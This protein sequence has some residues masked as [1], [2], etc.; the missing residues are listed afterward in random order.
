MAA[1]TY[2]ETPEEWFAK[3]A[4]PYQGTTIKG[5][6]ERTASSQFMLEPLAPMFEEAT[7]INIDF[8]LTSW[9][10]MYEKEI[11]DMEAGAGVYDF[12]Y[13]EQDII[14]GALERDWLTD[15]TQ[16]A[17]DN[18]D[19]VYPD[20]DVGDF[21]SFADNFLGDDGHLYGFPFE[22]FLK[23]YIYRKDLFEDPDIQAAFKEQYGWD[24]RPAVNWDEYLQIA[25]FFTKWGEETGEEFWGTVVTAAAHPAM[26]YEI[27]ETIW[28][29][30]GVYNWGIN[31]DNLKATSANGGAADSPRAKEAL[32]YW[33]DM[34]ENAPPEARMSTWD[35]VAASFAGGRTAQGFIYLENLGW[36]ALDEDRSLV[37]GNIGVAM[38]PLYPGVINDAA[39]QQGYVGYYDG[40]ALGIPHSSNNKEAAFLWLQ[41]MAR[42]DFQGDHA[43]S[44]GRIT[45]NSTFDDPLVVE[46]DPKMSNYFTLMSTGGPLFKGAPPFPFHRQLFE[47]YFL[48]FTKAFAGELTPDEACDAVAQEVDA[49]LVELGYAE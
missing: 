41:W 38:P 46:A 33:V 25:E 43:V 48:N 28:P 12:V 20:N 18:P 19:L 16:L 42:K 23:T 21:T 2:A 49:L 9:D 7:G 32:A 15:L 13:I 44:A 10:E 11:K 17:A 5:V 45:R 24:L 14:F 30:W 4:E 37:T 29:A 35:E 39:Q 36:M 3:A 31:M 6:S 40:G 26:T 27:I 22:A 1:P 8:E 47:V 34:L